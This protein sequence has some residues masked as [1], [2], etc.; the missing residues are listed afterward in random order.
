ML[1]DV[2]GELKPIWGWL[3]VWAGVGFSCVHVFALV[4]IYEQQ[5]PLG[6]VFMWFATNGIFSVVT[7][8]LVYGVI[9]CLREIKDKEGQ[10]RYI[11][12]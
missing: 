11:D 7:L 3:L 12:K 6:T 2:T 9:K 1:T 5:D 4:F 8:S 10:N